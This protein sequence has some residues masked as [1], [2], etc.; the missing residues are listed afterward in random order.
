MPSAG[1]PCPRC[2][3]SMF[4]ELAISTLGQPRDP[5]YSCLSCGFA[6]PP[7]ELLGEQDHST[8]ERKRRGP[9]H[10]GRELG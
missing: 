3:G 8:H 7:A 1:I 6:P 4:P 5:E 9:R 2:G 10:A